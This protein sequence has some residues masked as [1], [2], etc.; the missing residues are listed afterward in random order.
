MTSS[1]LENLSRSLLLLL[2]IAGSLPGHAGLAPARVEHY[3]GTAY[4]T[5]GRLLYTESH[6][7]RGDSGARE[8]LVLFSCPNGRPFARKKVREAGFKQAPSFLLEDARSGY[9]EG[10]RE[11]ASGKREV[12]VRRSADEAERSAPVTRLPGLVIDAGF[13]SFIHKHWDTLGT[14]TPQHFEFLLPSRLQAYPFRL[15]EIGD[16]LIDGTPV[17]RFR[18]QLDAWYAFAIP[19]ISLAYDRD[20]KRIREYTGASNIRDA[21]G[22]S[23]QVRIEFPD[24][25]RETVPDLRRLDEL[26]ATNLDG[27]CAL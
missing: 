10:V 1:N 17:R 13:N 8:L 9:R 26:E 3:V 5:S 15:S 24:N 16:D 6:W 11:G 19:A 22:K 27:T 21:A 4:D 14:G 25:A 18:L 20:S 7:I 12:F 2:G 23:L